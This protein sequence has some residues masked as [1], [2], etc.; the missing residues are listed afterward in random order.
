MDSNLKGY[1][2]LQKRLH[3]IAYTNSQGGPMM[4]LAK[5]VE[6]ELKHNVPRKTSVTGR[7]I[8]VAS[9]TASTARIE[10]N[11]IAKW[12]DIGTGIYGPRKHKIEPR[13]KKAL[14]FFA[15]TT[16]PGG[17]LRLTGKPRKGAAGAGA[18]RVVV[19]S[20]K[21]MKAQPYVDRSIQAVKT[22]LGIDF[23]VKRWND[24]A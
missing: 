12:L 20:V 6:G 9:T 4:T 21:G 17:S 13:V 11:A 3:A 7:S 5:A 10:G 16:G 24:A 1:T 18:S 15:G 22:K 2:A 8:H 14:A 19:R 23:I